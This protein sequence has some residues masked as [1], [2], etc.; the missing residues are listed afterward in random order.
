[1]DGELPPAEAERVQAHL[2]TCG[3]CR[4]YVDDI[5]AIRAASQRS[6]IPRYQKDLPTV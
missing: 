6:K 1:M 2:E 5:Q 4:S 3:V